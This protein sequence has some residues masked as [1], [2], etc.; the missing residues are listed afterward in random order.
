[1][2]INSTTLPLPVHPLKTICWEIHAKAEIKTCECDKFLE[3]LLALVFHGF[4]SVLS[5]KF[6]IRKTE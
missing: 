5:S 3:I 1:M 4:S 2:L 6:Q